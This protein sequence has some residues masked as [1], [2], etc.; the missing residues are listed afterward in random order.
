VQETRR[1]RGEVRREKERREERRHRRNSGLKPADTVGGGLSR[2][3]EGYL[4][5]FRQATWVQC[6]PH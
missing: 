1:R 5:P 4:G 6:V 2:V 3:R